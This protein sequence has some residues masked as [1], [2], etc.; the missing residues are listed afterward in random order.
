MNELTTKNNTETVN[1]QNCDNQYS[2]NFC[3]NCGQKAATLRYEMKHVWEQI[4]YAVLGSFLSFERGFSYTFKE[5]L[6]N[7]GKMIREYLSGKRVKHLPVISYI[8]LSGTVSVILYSYFKDIFFEKM[9]LP[10]DADSKNRPFKTKDLI[11]YISEHP[12]LMALIMIPI[13]AWISN[14][15]YKKNNYTFAEHLVANAYIQA[16]QTMLVIAMYPLLYINGSL[17]F[18]MSMLASY[19]YVIWAY[20]QFFQVKPIWKSI[21][22]GVL[23]A[24]LAYLLFIIVGGI[25]AGVWGISYGYLKGKI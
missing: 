16:Q 17:Y 18:Y 19:G 24:V 13:S 12:V 14:K 4:S 21:G 11:N 9:T 8:L 23:L 5:L 6:L 20:H 3:N 22:K 10:I 1:C 25:I 7:P 2:G 15:L